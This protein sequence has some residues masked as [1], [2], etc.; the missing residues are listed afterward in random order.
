[1]T[2]APAAALAA[3]RHRL[4]WPSMHWGTEDVHT[5]AW[6][7]VAAAAADGVMVH[8]FVKPCDGVVDHE[9]CCECGN[10]ATTSVL[11]PLGHRLI[12][13]PRCPEHL[14]TGLLTLAIKP[15]RQQWTHDVIE[16]CLRRIGAHPR[17]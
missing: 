6:P 16:H 12:E 15:R 7:H 13:H 3:I 17:A 1:M 11:A 5:E 14:T 9:R 4:T 8:L 10:R 2:D